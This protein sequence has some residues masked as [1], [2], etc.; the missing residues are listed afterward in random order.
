M[1]IKKVQFPDGSVRRVEV[2]EGASEEQILEFAQHMYQNGADARIGPLGSKPDFSN[3]RSGFASTEAPVQSGGDKV[4]DVTMSELITG[5]RKDHPLRGFGMGT[6]NVLEGVGG[7]IDFFGAPL[8]VGIE[9]VT[10]WP[11]RGFTDI[12]DEFSDF[13]GLPEA[14]TPTERVIADVNRAIAGTG[15]TM[16]A[17]L[18]AGPQS[19][20]G[21]FFAAN[22]WTQVAGAS[23]GAAAAGTTREVGGSPGAQ[24]AAGVV[25]GLAPAAATSGNSGL[26]RLMM[27]GGE[28]G[29]QKVERNL[30]D[31]RAMGTTPTAGQ[32][33]Q[34][35]VVT[36][37]ETLL[38]RVPGSAGVIARKGQAQQDEIG[39]GVGGFVSLLSNRADA[40]SAGRAIE[41]G[42][43]GP[44]GLM[45]QTKATQGRLYD[46]LDQQIPQGARVQMDNTLRTLPLLNPDIPGAPA[47]SPLFQN[48]R[49]RDIERNLVDDVWGPQAQLTRPDVAKQ[50]DEYRAWLLS[51]ADDIADQNARD[52]A[53]I[54]RDNVLRR[55]LTQQERVHE[56]YPVPTPEEID[57]EVRRYAD[58]LVDG[59]LP[60]EATRKLRTLVGDE[61]DNASIMSDVPRSKWR[62]LYSSLSDDMRAAADAAGP[63]AQRAFNRAND[64]AR[65]RAG[66]LEALDSVLSANGG[67]EGIFRAAM[68]GSSEGA[69]RLRA[70]MRSLPEEGR[71]QLAATVLQRMGRAVNS[72]QDDLGEVFSTQTFLTNWNKLSPDAKSTLFGGFG[73]RYAAN[74]D[75]LARVAANLREGGRVY[76]NPSGTAAGLTQVAGYTGLVSTAASALMGG[77]WA[78]PGLLVAGGA[79]ANV[80]ARRLT[81]PAFVE[82]LARTT[83]LPAS[84]INS[85]IPVL[86]QIAVDSGDAELAALADQLAE[87]ANQP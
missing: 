28:A 87:Q 54:A 85:Q 84:A 15:L 35:R 46:L 25:G 66:R 51:Q 53:A 5:K 18:L 23:T 56:P 3:V 78:I 41:R 4:A 17:G 59:R 62:G 10:G 30:A 82:W 22:P 7:V 8:K 27:R 55:A 63:D 86:R 57:A 6:R 49:I 1:P 38:S 77:S 11:Q 14:R 73:P 2:P 58:S 24:L 39:Q 76:A 61:I 70:V 33:T 9:K 26:L 52:A 71:K 36:G 19:T 50:A 29:R 48:S 68:Q 32:A 16:G 72:Q 20:L 40:G 65:A 34:N 83:E 79:T 43:R 31:F 13:V 12:A 44:G 69:T 64:Y 67:P 80:V 47:T 60:Y 21:R 81:N 42:V 37:I 74:M 45:E 75:K